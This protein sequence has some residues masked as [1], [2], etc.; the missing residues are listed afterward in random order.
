MKVRHING[1]LHVDFNEK[2]WNS[3]EAIDMN[4]EQFER[5]EHLCREYYDSPKDM[6]LKELIDVIV[7]M[8]VDGDIK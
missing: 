7:T 4:D 2:G 1:E 6:D 5:F 8:A 3:E